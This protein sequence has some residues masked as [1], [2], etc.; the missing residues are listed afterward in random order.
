MISKEESVLDDKRENLRRTLPLAMALALLLLVPLQ[1]AAALFGSKQPAAPA[2]N[3]APVAQ[4]LEIRVYRNVPYAG[5]FRA[6]GAEA[7]ALR[8]SVV[9]QPKKGS[10]TMGEDGETFFYTPAPGRT[11]ADSFAYTAADKS[12]SVSAPAT[13]KIR[14]VRGTSGVTYADTDEASATAAADLAEHG[15]FVGAKVG[16]DYFFEPQRTVSRGEFVAMAMAVG[17]Q[18]RSEVSVTGFCDDESIPAWARSYAASALKSGIVRGVRTSEGVAFRA[19]A[20]ITLS[21]AAT[22]LDRVLR[23]TDVDLSAY[24]GE[25]AD[26]W[27]AQAVANLES[28]SVLP[29]GRFTG[30]DL[31][32]AVTRAEAAKLLSAAMTL[33]RERQSGAF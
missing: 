16:K 8:F 10:V 15:V 3:G 19:D 20:A 6:A 13:V 25:A 22:V 32:R 18:R 17:G 28:V 31:S 9:T 26:A 12:G 11:G 29:S 14:I 21:E 24:R 2:E 23:V 1:G 33:V 30:A 4:K 5:V 27:C 7:G